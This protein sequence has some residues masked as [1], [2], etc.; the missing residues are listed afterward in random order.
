MSSLA[1]KVT[2]GPLCTQKNH[3][4][5]A[6]LFNWKAGNPLR[7]KLVAE[8]PCSL[9]TAQVECLAAQ[10]LLSLQRTNGYAFY[11]LM[12][13][14]QR[15]MNSLICTGYEGAENNDEARENNLVDHVD[16]CD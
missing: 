8:D 10:F 13:Q 14:F 2:L 7:G 11:H 3:Q 6:L 4:G 5:T 9:T 16:Q 12:L 15:N 1:L